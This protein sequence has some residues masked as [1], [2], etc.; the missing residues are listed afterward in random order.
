MA[1]GPRE[2]GQTKENSSDAE[3]SKAGPNYKLP[4]HLYASSLSHLLARETPSRMGH[5]CASHT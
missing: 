4:P 1:A 3:N 5:S 2:A